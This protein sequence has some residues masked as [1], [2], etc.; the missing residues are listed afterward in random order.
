MLTKVYSA[1][2]SGI[3]AFLVTIETSVERGA[4]FNIVGM[5]DT[6]VKEAYQRVTTALCQSNIAFP[7]KRT[8]IN[9]A[10]ADVKKE[11]ASFDLPMAI[12]IMTANEMLN[13]ACLE[14]T[15]LLGELSLDGTVQPVRGALPAAI[16]ARELGF[17]RLIVP[18][19][20]ATEAAVVNR[21]E[22]YGAASLVE[23][24]EILGGKSDKKPVDI[25]TRELFS[26]E[27]G[28]FDFDFSEVKGQEMVKRTLEVACAG[29][30]NILLIGP[31]GAGKSMMAKRIPSILP[32]LTLS[33]ALETTKIH[34]VAGK[35]LDGSMLMTRRPFRTPHHTVSPVALVGG[36]VNPM[37][38]EIS[39]AHN[40][41]LFL[42]E[43]PEFQRSVLEVMR[44]P[45]EDRVI[46]VSRAKYT[47]NYPASFMLVASMNPCPCGYFGHPTR[48]CTCPPGAVSRYMSRISG[49]M[50]DRIDLHVEIEPVAFDKMADRS[51]SES[52]EAIRRR[53]V[54]ARAIQQK[55]YKGKKGVHCNAQMNSSLIHAFAW[56][57][58]AGLAKLK[59]RM[60]K[61]NMSAR[62]FDRILR[63]A[64]TIADLEMV[65]DPSFGGEDIP[66]DPLDPDHLAKAA[67]SPILARHISEAIG[68]RTLDRG[69]YGNTF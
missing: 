49:P 29:G 61:L 40:G 53:V 19:A 17:K 15:M 60:E 21:L 67:A 3:D 56:P 32:P 65:A 25:N 45:I 37:P 8:I 30:H 44:Q 46:T 64:R 62:A 36:G 1:A 58:E 7:H 27:A 10:P 18:E 12:G 50:L 13:A 28:S 23:A 68:Y 63:V 38:G 66:F 4:T 51:P 69:N 20:N 26:R 42:D 16:R 57:D 11:G 9:L 34:S 59:E 33:E 35:L 52:S 41:V 31:P 55:R 47:V 54:S 22:V 48:R 24:V 43:F 39:L 2:I 14:D 5:A 6:A